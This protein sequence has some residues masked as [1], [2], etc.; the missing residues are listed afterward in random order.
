MCSCLTT[1]KDEKK[2]ITCVIVVWKKHSPIDFLPVHI[3]QVSFGQC[4]PLA[5]SQLTRRKDMKVLH[6]F[7]QPWIIHMIICWCLVDPPKTC[8]FVGLIKPCHLLAGLFWDAVDSSAGLFDRFYYIL[9]GESTSKA[10]KFDNFCRWKSWIGLLHKRALSALRHVYWNR[11]HKQ[12]GVNLEEL[13]GWRWNNYTP[14]SHKRVDSWFLVLPGSEST[15]A[16]IT[17]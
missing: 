3:L 6:K 10:D 7:A 14:I 12:K 8:S 15:I 11:P 2:L 13:G 4:R 17:E 1:G 16:E 5:A 9:T